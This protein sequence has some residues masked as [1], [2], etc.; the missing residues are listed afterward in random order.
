MNIR[1]IRELKNF[2]SQRLEHCREDRRILLIYA[3]LVL[4]SSGLVTVANYI[5]GS[6]I[7]NFG[8]LRNVSIRTTLSALQTM[9]P[10]VQNIFTMCL[11][12]GLIAAM[13]R[14]ARGQY[15]SQRTLKLG[16]DRFWVLLRCSLLMGLLV[17]AEVFLCIYLG[18]MVY[19]VTPFSNAAMEI[20]A[21]YLAD[22]TILDSQIV[23]TDASAEQLSQVIGPAF[24]FCGLFLLLLAVPMLYNFRMVNYIII[25]KPALGALA[26]MGESRKIMRGHRFAMFKLDLSLWWYY[27]LLMLASVVGYGDM[28]LS[29]VGV[30]LPGSETVWYFVF[31]ALYLLVLL[32]IY[33]FLRSRVEVVYS[34][35]YDTLKPEEKQDGGVV[36]GN[37]FQM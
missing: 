30:T 6:Q 1:N 13:L 35:A 12:L 11:E 14:I 16:F 4:G 9:L 36:L 31:Y 21:P 7:D 18:V 3:V 33:V 26:A 2:A 10:I 29:M 27:L 17:S 25:D 5:I 37:I 24:A 22:A 34:L 19:M 8:G 20:L 23:L 28:L 15:V 32:G